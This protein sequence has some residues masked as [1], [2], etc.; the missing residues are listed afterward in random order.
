MA[1]RKMGHGQSGNPARKA[2]EAMARRKEIAK[3]LWPFA[4]DYF[5][6][7][8]RVGVFA[9]VPVVDTD[10]GPS[11]DLHGVMKVPLD[12]V[13]R[14]AD[15]DRFTVVATVGDLDPRTMRVM[16]SAAPGFDE[17]LADVLKDITALFIDEVGSGARKYMESV[18]LERPGVASP[19]LARE[20]LLPLILHPGDTWHLERDSGD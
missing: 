4:Y 11:L 2:K 10:R 7:S 17:A 6:Q 5:S 3:E 18:L 15:A 20:M 14:R 8:S 12:I 16:A 19:A 13:R 1:K 9:D